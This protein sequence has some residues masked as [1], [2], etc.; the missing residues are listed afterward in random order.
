M[1]VGNLRSAEPA[2]K[3]KTNT[4]MRRRSQLSGFALVLLAWCTIIG[5]TAPVHERDIGD[6][7]SAGAQA[8][9]VAQ[10]GLSDA[11]IVSFGLFGP[12]SV[13]E[14]EARKAAQIL[15]TWFGAT[16]EPTVR[17]NGKRRGGVTARS[18]A[19]T[20]GRRADCSLQW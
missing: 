7:P 18:I 6:G 5:A 12:E 11:R 17:F 3:D 10:H 13:F 2:S 1:P 14:S 15:S 16:V 9:P 19:P 20:F 4:V 8:V